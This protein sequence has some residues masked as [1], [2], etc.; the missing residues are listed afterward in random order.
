M[1]NSDKTIIFL[2]SLVPVFLITG[3]ALPDLI[4]TLSA[5]YFLFSFIFI[6]KNYFFLKD[7]F[8]FISIVFWISILFISFYAYDKTK[9]FQDSFIFIRLLLIPTIAYYFFFND[10]N[11]II[12]VIKI[13]FVCICFVSID[14]LFQFMNYDTE[15]GF[16]E[17]L[18]GFKSEWYGRLTGPFGDELIPGAYVSK[19]GLLGYI[20]FFF[21]K[22]QKF[23]S[24]FE[25]LYLS[26]LSLVCFSSGERMAFATFFLALF[27]LLI[28]LNKKRIIILISILSSLLI[29]FLSMKFHPFYNDFKIISSDHYHQGLT[30]NK[31]F[32]CKENE[33]EIC[34]KII[35]LQPEFIEIIKNFNT[36]AY[37]EIY[38]VGILMFKDHPLTGVG[39]SNYQKV[40]NNF[41]KYNNHM[42]NYNCASHPH[43]IYI[44]WLTEGGL[45]SF[46]AFIFLLFT[47]IYLILNGN[48]S[49]SIKY[50]S[51][52][53]LLIMFW[54]IMSTGSLVKNWN[55]V[56]TFYII[57][58]CISLNRV[59]IKF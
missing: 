49:K 5:I 53:C 46:T 33:A 25:V 9:S 47:I 18:L 23:K 42:I 45:I 20:F 34:N 51:L 1:I 48:N 36:S 35:K 12:N 8:F 6:K 13:I 30:I 17:D 40:C 19:F 59:K 39:I 16:G 54:P 29:I 11:K 28:F 31:E 2:F 57:S 27:F 41:D 55:G 22:E 15:T 52:A 43:N 7:R 56:L 37:G 58:I 24:F 10:Q 44:Q 4:I 38:K 3:P 26:L 14:T 50:I 21:I 32:K